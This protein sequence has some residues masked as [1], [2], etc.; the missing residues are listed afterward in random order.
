MARRKGRRLRRFIEGLREREEANIM[1]RDDSSIRDKDTRR[2][3]PK[4]TRRHVKA[5]RATFWTED[6]KLSYL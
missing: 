6:A 5:V 4:K 2:K 3:T 1:A